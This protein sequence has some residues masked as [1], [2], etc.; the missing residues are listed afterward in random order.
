MSKVLSDLRIVE[1]SA[2]IAVPLAGMTLAQMGADVIRI[3]PIGGG[4]DFGRWPVDRNGRSLYWAGLNKGKRS[5]A[6]DLRAPEGREIAASLIAAPG[7]GAGIF[8][9]NL[10]ARDWMRYRTLAA[11]R[12]DLI[13]ALVTGN[14]DGTI[15]VDYTVNA[16]TGLPFLNA[17][18]GGEPLNNV[19]PVWDIAA[20]LMLVSGVLAAERRRRGDGVGQLVSLALSDVA[21]ATLGAL[22]YIAELQV[23]GAGRAPHGNE[24]YGSFGRAFRTRDQ[25][26][27]MVTAL[28]PRQW[29]ALVETTGIADRIPRIESLMGVDL[30]KEGGRY[31]ARAVIAAVLEPW[32]AARTLAEIGP[33][34]T[35]AGVCWAPFQTF[36]QLLAEDPRCSTANPIF[37]NV[38]QPGIGSYLMAGTP[39]DFGGAARET[40]RPAPRLGE[41]TDEILAG[42]LGLPGHAIGRLHDRGVVAGAA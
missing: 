40:A 42:V 13:M 36:A 39:L 3:D 31:A 21:L 1:A 14:R 41:H 6:L 20:A 8:L 17:Q 27:V 7:D 2:F 5:I 33:V 32:F 26:W 23:N 38:E 24:I 29:D 9:T 16:A 37:A 19:V 12:P 35:A 15:A 4:L 11:R 28:T 34:F 22:G 25:R 30:A 10:P 18:A